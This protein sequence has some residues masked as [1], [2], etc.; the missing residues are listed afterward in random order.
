M[1]TN[2]QPTTDTNKHWLK[3]SLL[4]KMLIIGGLIIGLLIPQTMIQNLIVER[5]S[6]R[7]QVVNEV[8]SKW[9]T[10]QQITGPVVTVPYIFTKTENGKSTTYKRYAHFLPNDLT[11]NGNVATNTKKRGIYNVILYDADAQIRGT[12][13]P[14]DLEAIQLKDSMMLWE[15]AFVSVGITDMRGITQK[16]IF[17]CNGS[18]YAFQPG[19]PKAQSSIKSGVHANMPITHPQKPLEFSFKLNVQGSQ[20]LRFIPIGEQTTVEVTSPW[21]DPKFDGAFLPKSHTVNDSGFVAKWQII[22]H[23]RNYAQQWKHGNINFQPSAFGVDFIIPVDEYQ[24]A[25]RSSKYA[26]LIIFLTFITFLVIEMIHHIQIHPFQYTLVGA[27]LVLFYSLLISIS[28]HFGFN[29]AYTISTIM[30]SAVI[31]MYSRFIFKTTALWSFLLAGLVTIYAFVFVVLNSQD[32]ALLIG[33]IGLF[34]VL[35]VVM[36]ATRNIQFYQD[37]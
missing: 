11:V 17:A 5:Q 10:S 30:T 20:N 21:A 22:N 31:G 32:Y 6:N 9:G 15:E 7:N 12:F 18:T 2:Q 19:I 33:S 34:A 4:V 36:Y 29:A 37:K 27:A 25:L 3:T 14:F 26:M 35:G 1:E 28:E 24:K 13:K 23:N 16:A 8:S